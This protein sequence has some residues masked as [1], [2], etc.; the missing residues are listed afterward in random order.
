LQVHQIELEMQ[1][2]ELH[3]ALDELEESRS[4][5]SDLYDFAPIGYFSFDTDGVIFE[6]NLTAATM[7]DIDRRSLMNKPFSGFV[8]RD[9]RDAFH[10]HCAAVLKDRTKRTIELRL[11]RRDKTEIF[12]LLESIAVENADRTALS[13]RTAVSDITERRKVDD[14]LQMSELHYRLLF[15]HM[16]EGYAYCKMLYDEHGRPNDFVYLIVN[17]AFEKLT[18]LK[19]VVGMKVTD[20]IPGIRESHPELL[21][22]Y[23]RVAA[24]GRTEKFE[25]EFKP[26]GMWLSIA[27]YSTERD[28]FTAV[29]DDI[30]L[31]K[32]VEKDLQ[33]SNRDLTRFNT[34]S[35][36]RELRM[37]DLKQEVNELCIQAGQPPRYALDFEEKQQ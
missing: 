13:I 26:L 37:I 24:T 2:E 18:G 6:A 20:V 35:V 1:N 11:S 28:H 36:G 16:L 4:R 29:F 22:T 7:L 14:L 12:V 30:T 19:N 25:I 5:Y 3:R 32:H 15:E 10:L 17:N 8:V 34:A 27:A 31:R 33:E 23:S 9:G 21:E